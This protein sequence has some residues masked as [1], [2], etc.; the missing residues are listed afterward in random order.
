M[1]SKRC[2]TVNLNIKNKTFFY[3]EVVNM[4]SL[5]FP[6]RPDDTLRG[7]RYLKRQMIPDENNSGELNLPLDSFLWKSNV[8][9][10]DNF[11][12]QFDSKSFLKSHGHLLP[13][14]D[15]SQELENN[16]RNRRRHI[17]APSSVDSRAA[18]GFT[19]TEEANV[20]MDELHS[21][22]DELTY[23]E[24]L[25]EV[26]DDRIQARSIT[27]QDDVESELASMNRSM[28][29]SMNR[30]KRQK[31][32]N[33]D[34][35]D[36]FNMNNSKP[37]PHHSSHRDHSSDRHSFHRKSFNDSANHKIAYQAKLKH[38]PVFHELESNEE[39]ISKDVLEEYIEERIRAVE[40]QI[41]DEVIRDSQSLKRHSPLKRFSGFNLLDKV[42][43][44]YSVELEQADESSRDSLLKEIAA[45]L[46]SK[47]Y[48]A[49]S[50]PSINLPK[51]IVKLARSRGV[52]QEPKVKQDSVISDISSKR[53]S[54]DFDRSRKMNKR[55]HLRERTISP[56]ST[57]KSHKD[58]SKQTTS[59]D[60]GKSSM[61]YV[62]SRNVDGAEA[63]RRKL[64]SSGSRSSLTSLIRTPESSSSSDENTARRN[65]VKRS[66]SS[67]KKSSII[68]NE[69]VI[70]PTTTN[71]DKCQSSYDNILFKNCESSY[72]ENQIDSVVTG[73]MPKTSIQGQYEFNNLGDN[74]LKMPTK[75]SEVT[76]NTCISL[77]DN[78][79]STN[80]SN[81]PLS[82]AMNDS[83]I[84]ESGEQENKE[85]AALISSVCPTP[86]LF[87]INS[88][89]NNN[90]LKNCTNVEGDQASLAVMEE[91]P[92][93]P[94]P[95]KK[96]KAGIHCCR[97]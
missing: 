28:V 32:N 83:M 36:K 23:E 11:E 82:Q 95:R 20:Q 64:K 97:L 40:M 34:F 62:E 17:A 75:S 12:E 1:Q 69:S 42:P 88:T 16:L 49:N 52:I 21:P 61:R 66:L 94:P 74:V 39:I 90:I 51:E 63:R 86:P 41:R 6:S 45:V 22:Y 9:K 81:E 72:V 53:S 48:V 70:A 25:F 38:K 92:P 2:E 50:D 89:V 54:T 31:I 29:L 43:E 96:L 15:N 84:R 77:V 27:S 19:S 71:I 13:E 37:T 8:Q 59:L 30:R 44:Q 67:S 93:A 35:E 76:S 79:A 58:F 33:K 80:I 4:D 78:L 7:T 85:A 26:D 91:T 18:Q 14:S 68:S 3:S 10:T 60:S 87:T 55:S 24:T 46:V 73:K 5:R 56:P 57:F 65:R 47:G